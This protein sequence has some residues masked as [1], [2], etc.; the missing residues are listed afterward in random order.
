MEEPQG[1][2]V[3]YCCGWLRLLHVFLRVPFLTRFSSHVELR[4]YTHEFYSHHILLPAGSDFSVTEKLQD[5]LE[6]LMENH[7]VAAA[8]AVEVGIR[9][10]NKELHFGSPPPA[11]QNNSKLCVNI[12]VR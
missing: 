6:H 10:R 3:K 8:T 7:T 11:N 2:K 1:E 9:R 5:E 12:H 4:F